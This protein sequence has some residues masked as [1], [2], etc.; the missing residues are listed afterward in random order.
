MRKTLPLALTGTLLLAA[1][2]YAPAQEQT[3]NRITIFDHAIFFDGYN[4]LEGISDES[5]AMID[6]NDGILRHRTSLYAVKLTDDQLSQ[7]GE[8]LHMLV[9]I[10]A[11]CDN[12]DRIGNINLA[13]VP[14][15][16]DTYNYEETQRLEIGRFITPFMNKNYEPTS[17]PYNFDIKHVSSILR[18]SRLRAEYDIW[19]E[20]ELFG[21]PYAANTQVRGCADRQDVFTGTLTFITDTEPAPQIDNHVLVPIVMKKPEYQGG[22]FNNYGEGCTDTPGRTVKTWTFTLPEDVADGHIMLVTSNHGANAGGEEYNRREH[23]VSFDGHLTLIYTPGR[24]SCEPFRQ[25]N[26]QGNGIYGW[27]PKSDEE[28]QSF[29]NWCPGDIIDNRVIETGPLSAGEHSVKIRVN[30]A[31]FVDKQGDIPVSMFFQGV[32]EGKMPVEVKQI[33]NETRSTISI[34]GDVCTLGGD[35]A[36]Q[37]RLY[38]IEGDLIEM[39]F[40]PVCISLAKCRPGVSILVVEFADGE[41]V[42]HKIIR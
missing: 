3:D 30:N 18:D 15:G 29:S 36:S 4:T 33:A 32:K 40:N 27:N 19:V 35:Q 7:I 20:F 10:G 13:L 14:K 37:A 21:I 24:T 2:T 26:T 23:R 34:S 31:K 5:K 39:E 28:W 38:D 16:A 1:N 17:V 11:L 6:P 22:N 25:Y 8:N 9:E 12:Y 42:C 41:T